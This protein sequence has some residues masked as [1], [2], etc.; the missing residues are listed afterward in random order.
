[1]LQALRAWLRQ[2]EPIPE[3]WQEILPKIGTFERHHLL[4]TTSE[5][6]GLAEICALKVLLTAKLLDLQ[7]KAMPPGDLQ[8]GE[9][10]RENRQH[11]TAVRIAC[12]KLQ[13]LIA[14]RIMEGNSEDLAQLNRLKSE[15]QRAILTT[16]K[17]LGGAEIEPNDRAV[18]K[19]P[20]RQKE[21]V[22][23]APHAKIAPPSR[24]KALMLSSLLLLIPVAYF[25]SQLLFESRRDITGGTNWERYDFEV[26]E[27]SFAAYA[28]LASAYLKE[29]TFYGVVDE[30][31]SSHSDAEKRQIARR[32][33]VEENRSWV[34]RI[35]F[36]DESGQ[37]VLRYEKDLFE[38]LR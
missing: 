17:M 11:E 3:A 6:D 21:T 35:V 15:L 34:R 30:E 29:H 18:S 12:E 27:E 4:E 13:H 33:F 26:E 32:L 23:I 20:R 10:I 16:T 5:N 2:Q 36:A 14:K 1:M 24:K 37:V 28:P 8:Q 38:E 25:S 31:W 9:L 19:L 7:A 22:R